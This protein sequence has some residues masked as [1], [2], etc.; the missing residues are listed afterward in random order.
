[1]LWNLKVLTLLIPAGVD[2]AKE[3]ESNNLRIQKGRKRRGKGKWRKEKARKFKEGERANWKFKEGERT[4]WKTN[5]GWRGRQ[6]LKTAYL[7]TGPI[8]KEQEWRFG[9]VL[10]RGHV[11][12]VYRR[13]ICQ[14]FWWQNLFV[15]TFWWLPRFQA[16]REQVVEFSNGW[17][18]S[19]L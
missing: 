16:S 2:W 15:K 6:D 11:D 12:L 1:M 9:K 3:G 10:E 19:V 14:T 7:K 8:D 13:Y 17:T 18:G 4:N 5:R